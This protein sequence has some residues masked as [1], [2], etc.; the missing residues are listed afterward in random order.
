MGKIKDQLNQ[1]INISNSQVEPVKP[2]ALSE[3]EFLG[4]EY[5]ADNN[6]IQTVSISDY[7]LYRFCGPLL[8]MGLN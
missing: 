6:A 5:A 7:I 3:L 2:D 8:Q 1:V 4:D